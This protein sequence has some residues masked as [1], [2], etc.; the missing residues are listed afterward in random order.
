MTKTRRSIHHPTLHVL[1]RSPCDR[2]PGT[3]SRPQSTGGGGGDCST[4]AWLACDVCIT[5]CLYHVCPQTFQFS[6][7]IKCL[8][9]V[10]PTVLGALITCFYSIPTSTMDRRYCH[11]QFTQI[12]DTETQRGALTH[13]KT[14]AGK[15]QRQELSSRGSDSWPRLLSQ[16]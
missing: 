13:P 8:Y 2:V 11:Q 10:R 12:K 7:T 9:H 14:P 16:P 5:S 3:V 15:W 6:L 1:C 4:T